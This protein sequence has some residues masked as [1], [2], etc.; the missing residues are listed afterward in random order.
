MGLVKRSDDED[1]SAE[2][3]PQGQ[4]KDYG[5]QD[6]VANDLSEPVVP[7]EKLL[8]QLAREEETERRLLKHQ[9][10]SEAQQGGVKTFDTLD[11]SKLAHDA[12][13]REFLL[14]QL[15]TTAIENYKKAKKQKMLRSKLEHR[16]KVLL[17]LSLSLFFSISLFLSFFLSFI[18]LP[19]FFIFV[20][21]FFFF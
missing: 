3:A 17:L 19:L 7:S 5:R 14:N 16:T 12:A 9:K 18:F 21:F 8:R 6:A 1:V 11:Q 4:T 13:E 20:L 2:H 10:R 15:R